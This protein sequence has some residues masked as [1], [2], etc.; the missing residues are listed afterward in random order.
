MNFKKWKIKTKYKPYRE[1]GKVQK[2]NLFQL[3]V[4]LALITPMTNWLI[5]FLTKFKRVELIRVTIHNREV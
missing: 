2:I 1:Y 5:P 3:L 4:V